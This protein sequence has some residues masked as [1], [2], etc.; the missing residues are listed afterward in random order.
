MELTVGCKPTIRNTVEEARRVFEAQMAHNRTPQA[1][2]VNN[3]TFWVGTPELVAEGMAERK[4][5]G[6]HTFLAE[7]PAP[8]DETLEWWIG[9][10]VPMADEGWPDSQ[11]RTQRGS[12]RPPSAAN[13]RFSSISKPFQLSATTQATST[14]SSTLGA[15]SSP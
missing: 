14:L 10:V 1:N 4:A 13:W 3:T 11:R 8:Y 15:K 6:F 2:V 12:G 7:T 5:L 9:E